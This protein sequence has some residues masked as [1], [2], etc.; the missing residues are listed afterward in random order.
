MREFTFLGFPPRRSAE[1]RRALTAAAREPRTTVFFES[2]H[3]LRQTL[4]DMQEVFD[5]RRLAVCRELTKT[6][7]E[8]FRGTAAKAIAHFQEPRGEF[9]IAVEAAPNQEAVS[10]EVV[11]HQLQ[12][13]RKRGVSARD[14]VKAVTA[15]TGRPHREVYA[16]WL[17]L[18]G[19]AP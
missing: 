5:D 3:R 16:L 2:P 11:R 4:Q 10:D 9:T 17:E 12:E 8:I 1:R 18:T 19:R 13:S 6:F 15:A 7:E 14:A